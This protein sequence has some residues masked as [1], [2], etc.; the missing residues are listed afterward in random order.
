MT[1][2]T[3][4]C[5][6]HSTTPPTCRPCRP[7]IAFITLNLLVNGNCLTHLILEALFDYVN[8]L[9]RFLYILFQIH[10]HVMSCMLLC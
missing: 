1:D 10:Y 7:V 4:R 9:V 8:A 6:D 2:D 3:T 5:H